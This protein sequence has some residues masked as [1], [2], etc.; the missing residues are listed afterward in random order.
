M[1]VR[2]AMV[3]R[4]GMVMGMILGMGGHGGE[5]LERQLGNVKL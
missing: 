3:M 4:M 5:I 2:M 1:M